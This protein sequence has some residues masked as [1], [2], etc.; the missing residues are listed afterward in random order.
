MGSRGQHILLYFPFCAN[1]HGSMAL[2]VLPISLRNKWKFNIFCHFIS[3]NSDKKNTRLL[4]TIIPG[5][6]D[7]YLSINLSKHLPTSFQAVLWKSLKILEPSFLCI[8]TTVSAC[9]SMC[10]LYGCVYTMCV[11]YIWTLSLSY[12]YLYI[13]CICSYINTYIQVD[14]S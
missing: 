13:L 7:I 14:I 2:L 1:S 6:L 8:L 11:F 12:K 10:N 9:L 3:R 4:Y 5:L